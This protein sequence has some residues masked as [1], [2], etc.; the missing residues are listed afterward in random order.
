MVAKHKKHFCHC[1][2]QYF[3]QLSAGNNSKVKHLLLLKG[4]FQRIRMTVFP[5]NLNLH[6][7]STAVAHLTL[8]M[9]PSISL[10]FFS[11]KKEKKRTSFVASSELQPI[12]SIAN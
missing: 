6:D 11:N 8:E 2:K 3:V 12:S 4:N 1:Y 5:I 7:T 10:F 9:H